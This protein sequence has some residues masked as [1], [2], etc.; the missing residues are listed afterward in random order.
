MI[1]ARGNELKI[2]IM[3][4]DDEIA[5]DPLTHSVSRPQQGQHTATEV[6]HFTIDCFPS[7][8][9]SSRFIPNEA[10]CLWCVFC[11]MAS[12]L[13]IEIVIFLIVV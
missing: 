12:S 7:G 4:F 13:K 9:G 8:K 1:G 10:L 5:I 11:S 3:Q 6:W 2:P